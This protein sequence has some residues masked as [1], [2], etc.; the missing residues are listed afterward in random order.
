MEEKLNDLHKMFTVFNKAVNVK[1]KKKVLKL[2]L[3]SH[4]LTPRALTLSKLHKRKLTNILKASL[5][6]SQIETK[7]IFITIFL[8][9]TFQMTR[10]SSCLEDSNSY[11]SNL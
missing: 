3:V 4:Y 11:Q 7:D 2:K 6:Q 10:L 1:K 9:K 5:K 8:T